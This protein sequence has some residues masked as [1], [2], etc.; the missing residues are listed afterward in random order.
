VYEC[1]ACLGI[2]SN[3]TSVML[4]SGSKAFFALNTMK[5]EWKD[6][7]LYCK[8]L[9]KNSHLVTITSAEKQ[10]AVN[11]FKKGRYTV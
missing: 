2:P 8:S 4:P 10:Q 5:L 3:F 1:N 9:S 11:D 6:A 7:D